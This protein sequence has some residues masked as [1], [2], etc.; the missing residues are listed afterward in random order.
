MV[1]VHGGEKPNA[2]IDAELYRVG[3]ENVYR[4]GACVVRIKGRQ[5]TILYEELG[6]LRFV[7]KSFIVQSMSLAGYK[8]LHAAAIVYKNIAYLLSGTKG[9]GKSTTL[10][11]TLALNPDIAVLGNDRVAYMPKN[12]YVYCMD[13][14]IRITQSTLDVLL[15]GFGSENIVVDYIMRNA[16]RSDRYEKLYLDMKGF[17]RNGILKATK[18]KIGGVIRCDFSK[19]RERPYI[20]RQ[21]ENNLE[22]LV[23]DD[24]QEYPEWLSLGS[25]YE[26]CC[27]QHAYPVW[28][29][30]SN[31]DIVESAN[32]LVECLNA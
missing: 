29:L 17:G 15:K 8:M 31:A 20:E 27:V 9:S 21:G 2:R 13:N 30:R 1:N 5:I 22:S 11:A 28:V 12:D 18:A 16:V 14:S 4:K 26:S 23:I 6:D 3:E 19:E 10:L 25:N 24:R 7:V 32:I